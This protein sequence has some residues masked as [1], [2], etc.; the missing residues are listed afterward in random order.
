MLESAL[1]RL[2][3]WGH[4]VTGVAAHGDPLCRRVG[5]INDEVFAECPRP[6]LGAPDRVLEFRGRE[7]QLLPV[8]L[9]AYG[10]EYA[11]ERLPRAL[12]L[13]DS[14]G[15]WNV[16]FPQIAERFPSPFGQLHILQHPC[17]WTRAFP[18]AAREA[19]A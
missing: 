9:A 18:T 5:F 11:T 17:W 6:E 2:R 10:L 1:A 8:P 15:V 3:A 19:A 14:G 4:V 13:S 12:Y 16:P 7:V